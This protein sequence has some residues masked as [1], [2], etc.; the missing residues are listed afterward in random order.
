ML[1]D[2]SSVVILGLSY[3]KR[4]FYNASSNSKR[5]LETVLGH[6]N[7]DESRVSSTGRGTRENPVILTQV[8]T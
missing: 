6:L 7:I 4:P 2:S 3:N 8:V 1:T 5:V